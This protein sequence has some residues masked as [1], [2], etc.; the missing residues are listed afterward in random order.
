MEL[1]M[2]IYDKS[3]VP[4]WG[5]PIRQVARLKF[6]STT[7]P[8]SD[9]GL[10]CG[11]FQAMKLWNVFAIPFDFTNNFVK[12]FGLKQSIPFF[13]VISITLGELF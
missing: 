4:D 1:I 5:Y 3:P 13:S 7:E 8:V 11:W 6:P 9:Y 2:P 10:G 12:G